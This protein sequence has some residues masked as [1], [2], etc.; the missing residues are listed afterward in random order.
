MSDKLKVIMIQPEKE[1]QIVEIE[2]NL[3]ALQNAVGGF[4][5]VIYPFEDHVGIVLN[6]EGKLIGLKPNRALKDEEGQLYDIIMGNFLVVGLSEDD[7]CSLT[8]EQIEKY[9][10]EY[11]QPYTYVQ[12]GMGVLEIPI[13]EKK[14]DEEHK[15]VHPAKTKGVDLSTL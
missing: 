15:K 10:E 8:D 13:Q 3:E 4:I 12:L 5:E 9:M 6:E 14:M 1:P 7:F 2:R 11:K